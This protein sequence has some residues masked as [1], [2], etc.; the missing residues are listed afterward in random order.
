MTFFFPSFEQ[1]LTQRSQSL[2]LSLLN[3][4]QSASSP[5]AL[6]GQ[7]RHRAW[8]CCVFRDSSDGLN[9]GAF[10]PQDFSHPWQAAN[11][12]PAS[13]RWAN[14]RQ[15]PQTSWSEASHKWLQLQALNG[16]ELHELNQFPVLLQWRR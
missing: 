16:I 15:Q 5:L 13:V 1:H 2:L 4:E 14:I 10:D 9:V 11:S 6:D 12:N 7:Q 8:S 3:M